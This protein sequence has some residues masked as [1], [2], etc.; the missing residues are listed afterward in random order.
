MSTKNPDG[1]GKN[2]AGAGPEAGTAGAGGVWEKF[3]VG[4]PE[5]SATGKEER[6]SGR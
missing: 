5:P 3:A 4:K 2:R 6:F 1:R